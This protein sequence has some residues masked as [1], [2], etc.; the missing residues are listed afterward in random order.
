M[1]KRET[2]KEPPPLLGLMND[3][4]AITLIVGKR[5]SG[6][7]SLA[8][9]LLLDKRAFKNKF[10][11]IIFF[12]PTF[13]GQYQKLWRALKPDGITVHEEVT[14]QLL[15]NVIDEQNADLDVAT[16]LVFDDIADQLK[17]IN[18]TVLGMLVCNSRQINLCMLVLSQKITNLPTVLRSQTDSYVA[19]GACSHREIMAL[20]DE[21]STV[22]RQQFVELFT[23]ATAEPYNFLVISCGGGGKF[24]L[25]KNMAEPI[26]YKT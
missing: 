12:S 16:L 17:H 13:R 3:D 24:Q 15:Q 6:K 19:F 10:D 21:A 1:N 18:T 26:Q 11:R 14:D 23:R 4:G 25:F 8:L 5:R 9:R 20:A 22:P 2:E 7:T